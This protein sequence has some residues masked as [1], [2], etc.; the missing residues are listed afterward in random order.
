MQIR[1]TISL[2]SKLSN[3]FLAQVTILLNLPESFAS[4]REDDSQEKWSDSTNSSRFVAAPMQKRNPNE[5][6]SLRPRRLFFSPKSM[7]MLFKSTQTVVSSKLY[8]PI[9]EMPEL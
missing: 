3:I 5:Q 8:T 4:Q 9:Q 1:A 6:P 2:D 7:M